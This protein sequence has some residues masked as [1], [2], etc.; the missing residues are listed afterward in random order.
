[1]TIF[2]DAKDDTTVLELKRIIE[3][4]F[5][6]LLYE[7]LYHLFTSLTTSVNE[8]FLKTRAFEVYPSAKI[9]IARPFDF[10]FT[11]KTIHH[12]R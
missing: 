4:K 6:P 5:S 2:T 10:F 9:T 7:I 1:M 11:F 3:G 8:T 12:I